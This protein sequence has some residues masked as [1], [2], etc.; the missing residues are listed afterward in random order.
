MISS[1]QIGQCLRKISIQICIGPNAFN[2]EVQERRAYG[3]RTNGF[4]SIDK[5]VFCFFFCFDIDCHSQC[6]IIACFDWNNF[7]LIH[8]RQ[9]VWTV[10]ARR[11]WR[12]REKKCEQGNTEASQKSRAYFWGQL[13]QQVLCYHKVFP[14]FNY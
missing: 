7:L 5:F 2:R 1:K 13:D 4:H 10:C 12:N 8:R 3:R 14:W 11:M 9:R 6:S